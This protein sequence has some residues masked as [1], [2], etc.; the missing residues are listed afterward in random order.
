ME[1]SITI[2][3]KIIKAASKNDEKRGRGKKSDAILTRLQLK[4]DLQ[5]SRQRG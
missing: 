5:S 3:D 2:E 4:K 1:P